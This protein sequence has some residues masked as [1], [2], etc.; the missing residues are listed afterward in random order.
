MARR[1][2]PAAQQINIYEANK[3]TGVPVLSTWHDARLRDVRSAGYDTSKPHPGVLLCALRLVWMYG[4][5]LQPL[6]TSRIGIG[7]GVFKASWMYIYRGSMGGD[8]TGA[9][10]DLSLHSLTN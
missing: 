10:W 6:L 1:S 7:V 9:R 5:R 2:P 8:T 3:D 4:D